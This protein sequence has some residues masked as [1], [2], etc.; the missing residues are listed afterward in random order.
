MNEQASTID[1][2][3]L[4]SYL[5]SRG[6]RHGGFWRG[7]MVWE[8]EALGRLLV[9]TQ[10]QHDIEEYVDDEDLLA[11]ALH[12]LAKLEDRPESELLLDI[13]EP[14]VDVPSFR[15]EPETPSGTIPL[16]A[17]V[18][19][20]QGIHDLLKIAALTREI[21]PRPLFTGARSRYV[22]NFLQRVRLGTSRPGSYIFDAR[23]PISQPPSTSRA[24]SWNDELAGREVIATLHKALH[25]AH[26]AAMEAAGNHERLD[27]FDDHV[28]DGVSANL[29][30]TLSDLSGNHPVSISFAWA[31][32]EPTDL[33]TEPLTFTTSL[34]RTL[35]AAGRELERLAKTGRVIVTGEVETLQQPIGES[36][37][38]KI[39][40][41]LNSHAATSRRAI[42]VV[43]DPADYQRAFHAQ[44]S[45]RRLRVTGQLDPDQ[46]R[47]EMRPDPGGFEVL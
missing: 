30:S 39:R 38:V 3:A 28:G 24:I 43:L 29:C 44:I 5:A 45:K 13:A 46:R 33:P 47:L 4:S 37:R 7:A 1:P 16:P 40:G 41:E 17:A 31:R 19:A 15:L 12:K 14:E 27:A 25:A 42:W 20:V 9:P 35:S 8:R 18:K 10:S 6:W 23:V 22:D 2:D 36:P 34:V 32:A 21:G 26:K 11:T